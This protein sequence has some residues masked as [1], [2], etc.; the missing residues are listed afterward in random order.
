MKNVINIYVD[1]DGVQTVYNKDD[2]VEDMMQPGYFISRQ[3]HPE[4]IA[5]L[6]YLCQDNRFKVTI[7]SAVFA[8]SHSAYEKALWLKQQG[9]SN[10]DTMFVPCGVPKSSFIANDALNIL[11][12]DFS[13]NLFQWEAAGSNFLG[14]KFLNESNG[15]NGTWRAHHGATLS[16]T[17]TDME[18]YNQLTNILNLSQEQTA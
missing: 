18:L 12:D 2:L 5:F 4:V 6:K 16:Y 11:I 7:L 9:L 10:V 13:T 17:M 15:V 8:D 1:M 14:I 3:A